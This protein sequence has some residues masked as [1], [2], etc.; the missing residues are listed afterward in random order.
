[1]A[2]FSYFHPNISITPLPSQQTRAN[3]S[4][5]PV[6]L[7]VFGLNIA[8]SV[9]TPSLEKLQNPNVE[10][11]TATILAHFDTGASKTSIDTALAERLGLVAVGLSEIHTAAGSVLMPNFAV[12]I[13]FPGTK[14]QPFINIPI[15]SCKLNVKMDQNGEIAMSPQNFGLLIGRD[16]MSRWNIVWNGPTSSV[17]I[18][19]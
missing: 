11:R 19:D 6:P 14:L 18:S 10:I 15:S 3:L 9:S 17:F 4:F 2:Q 8:V 1:M 16:I 7:S 12:D 13:S 5:S